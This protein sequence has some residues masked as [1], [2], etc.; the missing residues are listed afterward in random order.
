MRLSS[1]GPLIGRPIIVTPGEFKKLLLD[2]PAAQIVDEY[3]LSDD[4]GPYTT[5]DALNLLRERARGVFGLTDQ[6][7]IDVIVVG[8]AKLGFSILDKHGREGYRPAYRAYQPGV[9]DIDVAVVSPALY[10]KLWVEL[11]RYGANQ[12]RFPWRSDLASYML[13]GWIRP[14]KFPVNGPQRCKDWKNLVSEVGRSE[15]FRYKKLRCALY[16]SKAFLNHYQQR[17]VLDAQR[18]ERLE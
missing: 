17:G 9:S 4:P 18:A 14:D 5:R 12:D 8:S 7:P 15:H 16:H 2:L 3:V 13:H 6:Q 1:Y 11:A 10:G